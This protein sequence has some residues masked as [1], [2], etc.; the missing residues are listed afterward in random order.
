MCIITR[1]IQQTLI[2]LKILFY[3]FKSITIYIMQNSKYKIQ[4]VIIH[5]PM[6]LEKAKKAARKIIGKEE[7]R[8]TENSYRFKNMS[9]KEFDPA[10]FKSKVINEHITL[11]VGKKHHSKE[12]DELKEHKEESKKQ[13]KKD[14]HYVE[15]HDKSLMDKI[16][17][18]EKMIKKLSHLV[19]SEHG[20]MDKDILLHK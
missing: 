11:V 17:C 6:A 20:K 8:E 2:N 16:D 10:T 9:K 15:M 13:H 4:S 3:I 18:L 12:K 1:K 5:K 7:H 14:R 19:H